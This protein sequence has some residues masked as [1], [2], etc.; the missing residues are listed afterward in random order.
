VLSENSLQIV[1]S[2]NK[3]EEEEEEK[4]IIEE[5]SVEEEVVEGEER[6][7]T[8]TLTRSITSINLIAYQANF[9][10]LEY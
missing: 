7:Y 1:V 8:V 10:L 9:I 3:E 2:D 6:K 5:E 4:K